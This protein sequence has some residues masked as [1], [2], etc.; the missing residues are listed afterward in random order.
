MN[1]PEER[2]EYVLRQRERV[3]PV[4]S[5]SPFEKAIAAM[6]VSTIVT[7]IRTSTSR[8][9]T[10]TRFSVASASVIECPTVNAVTSQTSRF[11]ATGG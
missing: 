7:G 5:S 3:G 9:F 10:C 11:H 6:L 4:D 8:A 2:R 1:Q